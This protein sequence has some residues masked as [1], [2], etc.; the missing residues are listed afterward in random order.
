MFEHILIAV[1]GSDPATRAAKIGLE[2]AAKYDATVDVLH[3]MQEGTLI[4]EGY[5][6]KKRARG[7]AILEAVTDLDIADRPALETHLAEG[8]AGSVIASF[9]EDHDVDLVVMGRQ[10]RTGL[11]GH[12]L[13]SVTERVLRRIDIPALTVPGGEVTTSTGRVYDNVLLT[14]DG[15]EIAERA[16]PYGEALATR[17]GAALHLLTVVDVQAEAGVFNAGGVSEEYIARLETTG[18]AALDRLAGAVEAPTVH[19]AL[20]RGTAA[21]EIETYADENDVDL[22]V[23]ASEGQTNLVGQQLGSTTRR[24]LGR[25]SRPVLVVPADR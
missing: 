6:S 16:A 7:E 5:E 25:T 3:V 23:M 9:V 20:T 4:G 24:V 2:L 18:E 22:I 13:G 12:V 15:S 14:T 1:D 8:A 21:G 11:G 19:S 10:G 17:T